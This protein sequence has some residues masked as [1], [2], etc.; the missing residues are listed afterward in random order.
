M[1][2]REEGAV[3]NTLQIFVEKMKVRIL[4]FIL[5]CSSVRRSA[6]EALR[7]KP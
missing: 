2:W 3:E 1:L 5:F 4:M 7:Y 6:V